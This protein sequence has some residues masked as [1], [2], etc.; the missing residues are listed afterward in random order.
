MPSCE[1]RD[2]IDPLSACQHVSTW[3]HGLLHLNVNE[4]S[5]GMHV[6]SFTLPGLS[7]S[8]CGGRT[9]LRRFGIPVLLG[10]RHHCLPQPHLFFLD[11]YT[12]IFSSLKC[13][14]MPRALSCPGTD[15]KQCATNMGC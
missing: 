6:R 14:V 3:T 7:L 12:Y 10:C 15:S 13:K 8:D 4:G 1:G 11:I 2:A 5:S 9:V